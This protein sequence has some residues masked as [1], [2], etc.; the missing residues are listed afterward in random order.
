MYRVVVK[1]K[2]KYNN[3]VMG[4]RYCFTKHSAIKLA[5][6]FAHEECVFVVEKFIRVHDDIFTWSETEVSKKNLG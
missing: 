4:A 3:A 1:S 6:M 5:T 2:G